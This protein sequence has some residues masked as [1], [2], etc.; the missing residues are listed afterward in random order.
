M[1]VHYSLAKAPQRKLGAR[2]KS[3]IG[4]FGCYIRCRANRRRPRGNGCRAALCG[5]EVLAGTRG[6]ALGVGAARG[7]RARPRSRPGRAGDTDIITQPSGPAANP[8][9]HASSDESGIILLG[10][11]VFFKGDSFENLAIPGILPGAKARLYEVLALQP[12]RV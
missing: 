7:A 12:A 8:Q 10:K 5:Q 3:F 9:R 4:K 11:R 2:L 1:Y 6:H